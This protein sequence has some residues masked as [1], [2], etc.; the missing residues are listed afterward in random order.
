MPVPDRRE[1]VDRHLLRD[2]AYAAL[3]EAIVE[4]TLC[5]GEILHDQELCDW[6]ALSRTPVRD[7]M[8]RLRDEGLV[9]MSPQRYTRVTAL[10]RQDVRDLFPVLGALHGLAT[11]LAVPRLAQRDLAELQRL[12]EAFVAGLRATDPRAAHESDDRFHGV[13]L[14]AS[15]NRD[16]G[17][18]LERLM[19]RL[20]RFER[21]LPEA[22]P[23][24]R[25]VAQHQAIIA[26]AAS[27]D[28]AAAASAVRENWLTLGG[29]LDRALAARQ[30]A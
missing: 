23:G 1:A 8:L 26:R 5:P 18:A 17:H 28:A 27:G 22:L 2:T 7:A 30:P 29:V 19:A 12:N 4:G 15:G 9:E 13:F 25:S 3:R 14:H 21:L 10:H 11:E 24:R 20:R 16:V 6:L